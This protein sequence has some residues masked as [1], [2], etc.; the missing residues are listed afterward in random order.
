M[1]LKGPSIKG[2]FLDWYFRGGINFK[3]WNLVED[4]QVIGIIL[5]GDNRTP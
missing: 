2:L 4:L 1:L 3:K 5:E